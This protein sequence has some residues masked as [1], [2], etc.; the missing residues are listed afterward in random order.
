MPSDNLTLYEN[1]CKKLNN[2]ISFKNNIKGYME[3]YI[4]EGNPLGTHDSTEISEE[5]SDNE[6]LN[7]AYLPDY[8]I[9]LKDYL[10]IK[11]DESLISKAKLNIDNKEIISRSLEYLINFKEDSSNYINTLDPSLLKGSTLLTDYDFA[12]GD[13][14]L[15]NDN[16]K[17]QLIMAGG[18][19]FKNSE[20]LAIE[21]FSNFI[22]YKN[23]IFNSY[24][25]DGDGINRRIKNIKNLDLLNGQGILQIISGNV[26]L[27]PVKK[28]G[29]YGL[30]QYRYIFVD[31]IN[32]EKEKIVEE[33]NNNLIKQ[34]YS[35]V[36]RSQSNDPS[37]AIYNYVFEDLGLYYGNNVL[38]LKNGKYEWKSE[39]FKWKAIPIKY[40]NENIYSEKYQ[41]I[42]YNQEK[43]F[44]SYGSAKKSNISFSS[45]LGETD[46][47]F[48]NNL[49]DFINTY[50][51]LASEHTQ[52]KMIKIAETHEFKKMSMLTQE[53]TH[54]D[55]SIT[56]TV[57][58]I[59]FSFP[60][61]L[62]Y[63]SSN[64]YVDISAKYKN[65]NKTWDT[66]INGNVLNFH[67]GDVSI[68]DVTHLNGYILSLSDT[69]LDPNNINASKVDI[70]VNFNPADANDL[71]SEYEWDVSILT[72]DYISLNKKENGKFIINIS[73]S[74]DERIASLFVYNTHNPSIKSDIFT[75]KIKND[76]WSGNN[77]WIH[78]KFRI[79]LDGFFGNTVDGRY[80]SFNWNID[81]GSSSQWKEI[82]LFSD[83]FNT[84]INNATIYKCKIQDSNGEEKIFE[85]TF[86]R[87][88]EM[89]NKASYHSSSPLN[90]YFNTGNSTTSSCITI[91][92]SLSGLE[93]APKLGSGYITYPDVNNNNQTEY[94]SFENNTYSLLRIEVPFKPHYNK[95]SL[96]IVDPSVFTK[97]GPLPYNYVIGTNESDI[98]HSTH[99]SI[100]IPLSATN[101]NTV[102]F[103]PT[104]DDL[105]LNR[106]KIQ[107][108]RTAGSTVVKQEYKLGWILYK[109]RTRGGGWKGYKIIPVNEFDNLSNY[110]YEFTGI[111]GDHSP[112][113][114][115]DLIF[116]HP[117]GSGG[118]IPQN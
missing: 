88:Y 81:G 114:I 68:L 64:F 59:S 93:S 42:E 58:N 62:N 109:A 73:T 30:K 115:I 108:E 17:H 49:L 57:D 21:G 7:K 45:E 98:T 110:N 37:A 74:A 83:G 52:Y 13:L 28:E 102:T 43:C 116:T 48:R 40:Y 94:N 8:N 77:G 97:S 65:T 5:L 118:Y 66:V 36:H 26:G 82:K 103:I 107:T 96:F 75:L 14:L 72:P 56:K 32:Y 105:N 76:L 11:Y 84:S 3:T 85:L 106:I 24:D 60:T 53:F 67:Y 99:F 31:Y 4:S 46:I 29:E 35:I 101:S 47:K 38:E 95:T 50:P 16:V 20:D 80:G 1:I 54:S 86:K 2:I 15:R 111:G 6:L 112:E 10:N 87:L 69:S 70:S 71:N 78:L 34:K 22:E 55:A 39:K 90:L 79:I 91:N 92:S 117:Y 33:T 51:E 100:P 25:P 19:G 113:I 12:V 18:P 27:K 41:Y 23:Y 61:T 63:S 104:G 44:I 9:L 89:W